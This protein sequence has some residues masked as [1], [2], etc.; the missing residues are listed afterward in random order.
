RFVS[1]S[2][3]ADGKRLLLTK[4]TL[5]REVWRVPLGPD[6]NANGS[7]AVRLLET[8]WDPF[9]IYATRDGL[10]LLFTSPATGSRNLWTMPLDGSGRPVQITLLPGNVVSHASLSPDKTRVAFAS[11]QTGNTEIWVMN[12]D[13]SNPTQ[14]THNPAHEYWP[15][16]S[17]DG[18]WIAFGSARG[19]LWKVP[20]IGGEPTQIPS[21][22]GFRR[23]DWSPQGDRFVTWTGDGFE[24]SDAESGKLLLSAGGPEW[25][26][27]MP[28]WSPDGRHFSAIRRENYLN[29][30]VWIFDAATGDKRLAAQFQGRFHLIFRVGWGEDGKSLIV[31][32][33]ES[34][35]HIVLLENF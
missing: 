25:Q 5:E 2:V 11:N 20:A 19:G 23:G 26:W 28:V 9:W 18:K 22:A 30:S 14:L 8:S 3:S 15:I 7:A 10:T 21:L 34:V 24:V 13:G 35:S 1:P 4:E 29:D 6:P 31:N 12:V 33:N 17:P 16:W 32:R 27:A